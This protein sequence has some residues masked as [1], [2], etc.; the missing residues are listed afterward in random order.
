MMENEREK[1]SRLK[2]IV[3]A[4]PSPQGTFFESSLLNTQTFFALSDIGY[5]HYGVSQPPDSRLPPGRI[6]LDSLQGPDVH[7]FTLYSP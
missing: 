5:I 7:R 2:L 3:L 6:A 4:V 1:H